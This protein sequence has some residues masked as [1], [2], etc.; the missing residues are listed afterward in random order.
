MPRGDRTG[1][2]GLGP[3]TGRR[4]GRCAG[5][6]NVI[7]GFG[8]GR[9]FF[10]RGQRQGGGF[11]F[12]GRRFTDEPVDEKNIRDEISFMKDRLSFLEGL[13]GKKKPVD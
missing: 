4:M 2:Q 13:L 9:G 8:S 11:G 5:N 10:G 7:K 12:F 1:P 6:K 3:M